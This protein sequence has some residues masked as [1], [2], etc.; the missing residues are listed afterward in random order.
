MS[1]RGRARLRA[2][3][4][5]ALTWTT[6]TDRKVYPLSYGT[7]FD[8]GSVCSSSGAS[9]PRRC[10]GGSA[11]GSAG[12]G[13]SRSPGDLVF[14]PGRH[15]RLPEDALLARKVRAE[16]VGDSDRCFWFGIL[17]VD[18]TRASVRVGQGRGGE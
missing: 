18:T 2:I 17:L 1:S 6:R 14:S 16:R 8:A 10:E 7:R 13:A 5:D 15:T 3:G 12:Q 4:R 11:A 9:G